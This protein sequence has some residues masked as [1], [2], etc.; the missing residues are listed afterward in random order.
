MR[1]TWLNPFS[2]LP[3][4]ALQR[5][6]FTCWRF[7]HK[8]FLFTGCGDGGRF[9]PWRLTAQGQA[10]DF[11]V[12]NSSSSLLQRMYLNLVFFERGYPF[13]AFRY[14]KS[15]LMENRSI[16][17]DSRSV[18]SKKL[19]DAGL[20][21]IG[22]LDDKNGEFKLDEELWRS[23]LSPVDHLLTFRLLNA[24]PQEWRKELKLNRASIY[25]NTQY[26]NL[27]NFSLCVDG[28]K[29]FRE[30]LFKIIV[31]VFVSKISGKPTAMKKHDKA[32][33]Q[34]PFI[35]IGRR[36]IYCLLKQLCILN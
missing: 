3:L 33:I 30:A 10:S 22:N 6:K 13:L 11:K 9:C 20:I 27:S 34:I 16:C 28:T 29:V 17:I 18:Y 5:V 1:L 15:G 7:I 2:S 24:F 14:N 23:S 35:L 12:T 36:F 31:P 8:R 25:G 19:F 32:L 26:Q 21:K 4:T